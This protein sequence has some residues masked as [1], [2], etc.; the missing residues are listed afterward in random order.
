MRLFFAMAYPA[1]LVDL[2]DDLH[3]QGVNEAVICPGSRNAPIM[4]ALVRHGGFRC[5]SIA[6]ERSAGFFGLGLALKSKRP[7]ILCCTSGSAGL[8][9]APAVVEAFFQEVPLIVL[10]A[11]RPAEW[12]GQWDGQTIYQNHLY[13]KHVKHFESFEAFQP[14][15]LVQQAL[16][17]PQGP[18]H[19]NIAIAEPFYP[20]KGEELPLRTSLVASQPVNAVF[21]WDKG[22]LNGISHQKCLITVGQRP[23]DEAENKLFEQLALKGI[24]VIGD[25]SANLPAACEVNHDLLLANESLWPNL[26]ADFHI[27]FGK[28]FVSKRIK[29]MMRQFKPAKSYLVHPN[30]IERPDPFQSLTDVIQTDTLSVL[31]ELVTKDLQVNASLNTWNP[32]IQQAF[33]EKKAWNELHIYN[34]IIQQISKQDAE[35]HVG[36]SLAIR[37][38]N[39]T[40]AKLHGTEVF[41]NRGTSGIDGSLSTAVGAS[42]STNKLTVALLGDV[43]FH[44]DRNALWNNYVG[45]NM[46]IIVM[47]NAGGAIFQILDGAKDLAELGEFMVTKQRNTAENS[48]KDAGLSYL[49]AHDFNE[50][51]SV[52]SDFFAPSTTGKVLEIFTDATQNTEALQSYMALFKH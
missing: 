35:I 17:F 31:E 12:I 19:M 23:Y 40:A 2:I 41:S 36:N 6:D 9:F 33:F 42:Q 26:Q 44:Y 27:H 38:I 30:P 25:A 13:G 10:T 14:H 15:Q 29:Q 46:R 32:T 52:L 49:N 37:Y 1:G 7:V 20:A 5:Y 39:W 8:N 47:N 51:D 4:L 16:N 43:S 45:S 18:V 21:T 3:Q 11:D 28:S 50:L 22:L 34:A 24:P 48:A